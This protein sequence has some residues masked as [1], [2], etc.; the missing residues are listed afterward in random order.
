MRRFVL[1]PYLFLLYVVLNPL[2]N[3][4]EQVDPSL[5]LRPL[6]VLFL[7]TSAG[8]VLLYLV[9]K[10]W[11]YAGY[12]ALLLLAFFLASGHLVRVSRDGLPIQQ[13]L[14]RWIVL[15][16]W[17]ILLAILG[18]KKVWRRFGGS[19]VTP[20]LN[21]ILI[22]ALISQAGVSIPRLVQGSQEPA[23]QGEDSTLPVTGSPAALDC[24]NRPDIYYIILDGYGRAD[25]LKQIYG[26]DNSAFLHSLERKGFYI[27]SQSHSNYTQTIFSISSSLN[28]TYPEP[29][30]EGVGGI[31]YFTQLI[32]DNRFMDLLKRCGY[33]TV[34]FET[35]FSFT[36]NK[37]VDVYLYGGS[38]IN[39]FE[40]LI[41]ADTPLEILV[42]RLNLQPPGYSTPAHRQRVLFTFEQLRKIP[43]RPGPKFVFAH[44]LSPHPPFIFD[45][46]GRPIEPDRSHSIADGDEFG[47]DWEEYRAGYAGQVQFVN[48]MLERT[49]DT[50]LSRS[51][52]PPVI[53]IQGDHGPGG[54][55]DWDSPERSCLWERTSILNAY[56]LPDGGARYLYPAITPVNSFI[57]ILNVYFGAGMELLPDDTYFTSHRLERQVIDITG[58][59]NSLDNCS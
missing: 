51:S 15:P 43:R 45:A 37:E 21:F 17:G 44:I 8:I 58:E 20:A 7:V 30:P 52:R 2:L 18:L 55:L 35:G 26:V 25:V 50:I 34:A 32:T 6:V 41:L 19:Q 38:G 24:A 49:I 33:K 23:P 42:D 53:I 10:D 56:Y 13:D 40:S 16:A 46:N 59:R 14:I 39:E 57:T 5:A 1:Y 28:S 31:E 22:L 11:Q 3:N 9:F 36:D 27:A 29:E 12:L 54:H 47:G 48:R 4:L